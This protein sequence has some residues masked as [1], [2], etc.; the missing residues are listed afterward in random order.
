MDGPMSQVPKKRL[1]KRFRAGVG[2][3]ILNKKGQV[4]AFERQDV[5]GAWQLPQGGLELGESVEQALYREIREETG[6]L[7]RHLRKTFEAPV[8]I[9]YEYPS[10][11]TGNKK[12]RGQVHKWFFLEIVGAE[13]AID[14]HPGGEFTAW[15]WCKLSELIDSVPS[16]RREVYIELVRMAARKDFK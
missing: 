2:A 6:L 16:F 11:D 5:P 1:T 9:G 12:G 10:G 13:G 14:V 15:R 3:V 7:R 4:L 8:W